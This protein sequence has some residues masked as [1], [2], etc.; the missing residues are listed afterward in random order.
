MVYLIY[1]DLNLLKKKEDDFMSS[2]NIA[3]AVITKYLD[4]VSPYLDF[5]ENAHNNNIK[6]KVLIV[7]YSHGIDDNI[8]LELKNILKKLKTELKLVKANNDPPLQK[9]L[10]DIG[11]SSENIKTLTNFSAFQKYNLLPYGHYRN[12]ALLTALTYNSSINYLYF[13]DTDVYPFLLKKNTHQIYFENINFF[14]AHLKHL[15]STSTIITSSDYSGHYILPPIKIGHLKEFLIGLEKENCYT[16]LQNTNSGIKYASCKRNIKRTNKILGGN[17]AINL[18]FFEDLP[19]FFSTTYIYKNKLFLGRGEDTLLTKTMETKSK[20][21]IDIDLKIF[22][23]TYNNFPDEILLTDEK[24]KDRIYYASTGWLGRNPFINWLDT[25][26]GK[27]SKKEWQKKTQIE[28]QNLLIG[29][30]ELAFHLNDKRF[31]YLGDIYLTA[32]YQLNQMVKSY[33]KTI[34]AWQEVKNKIKKE[35][36]ELNESSFN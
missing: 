12:V 36:C 2:K 25:Q 28:Y 11:I 10:A 8:Y 21:I 32:Y 19:P 20:N 5:I 34:N 31:L 18:Q 33:Y 13:I 22:H 6:I 9:Q 14:N 17:L 15:K 1:Y 3:L 29:S 4:S 35:E 30:R 23:N 24:V 16:F 27:Q 26:S 7:V